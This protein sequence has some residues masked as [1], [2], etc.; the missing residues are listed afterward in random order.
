M[1]KFLLSSL[2]AVSLCSTAAMADEMT[3]YVSDAHCG[4]KHDAPSA[5]N[6]KCVVDMCIKGGSDPVLVKEGKVMKFDDA[7]KKMAV[8][9][10]G[11]NVKIDGTMNGDMIKINSIDKAE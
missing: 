4:A 7:S 2:L 9:H 1:S 10:A 3:G 5:K 11:E 6:T 8:A